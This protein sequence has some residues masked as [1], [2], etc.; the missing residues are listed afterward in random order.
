MSEHRIL[1]VEDDEASREFLVR[2]LRAKNFVLFAHDGGS[3]VIEQI[4]EIGPDAVLLD[5]MLPHVSGL[6][7][8]KTIREYWSPEQIAVI[9]VSALDSSEDVVHGLDL[10][11]NDYV[12]K[13]INFPVLLARLR[14][15][16]ASVDSFRRLTEEHETERKLSEL[17]VLS[18]R[19]AGVL[20]QFRR[21]AGE[22]D[23]SEALGDAV[24][25]LDRLLDQQ[26]RCLRFEPIELD[27][28]VEL[29]SVRDFR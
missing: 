1:I 14:T 8:L 5:I 23:A 11:A 13:P 17:R 22:Q 29:L 9:L 7:I 2:R 26:Y 18:E 15:C 27:F 20:G 24:A 16:L 19:L 6:D 28:N 25:E 12:V 10:G 3:D 4:R 21:L